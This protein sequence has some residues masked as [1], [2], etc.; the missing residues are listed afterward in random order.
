MGTERSWPNNIP[1][2]RTSVGPGSALPPY[3]SLEFSC[4]PHQLCTSTAW[5]SL[6]SPPATTQSL[7]WD[8][9]TCYLWLWLWA[10]VWTQR[11][12]TLPHGNTA[13][14]SVSTPARLG[15]RLRQWSHHGLLL[16]SKPQWA[17]ALFGDRIQGE[18]T[19]CSGNALLHLAKEAKPQ[20]MRWTVSSVFLIAV[21]SRNRDW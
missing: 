7:G 3:S 12:Q 19:V 13:W 14:V 18:R 6:C 21:I 16:T 11:D 5:L 8:N 15:Q 20:R 10:I 1:A 4:Q 9:S 17:V 2:P